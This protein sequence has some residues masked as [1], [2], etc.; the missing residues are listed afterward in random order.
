MEGGCDDGSDLER[1]EARSAE[2]GGTVVAVSLGASGSVMGRGPRL[3]HIRT[4]RAFSAEGVRQLVSSWIS[5]GENFP[6]SPAELT[7]GLGAE[8][9]NLIAAQAGV[10]PETASHQLAELLPSLIDRL[11]PQ[12][13]VPEE[14]DEWSLR[15]LMTKFGG[16]K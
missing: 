11:T 3:R 12:G 16:Q 2:L 4:R 7:Q 1:I 8:N 9:V 10:P 13:H 14:R 5:T 15:S 6:I